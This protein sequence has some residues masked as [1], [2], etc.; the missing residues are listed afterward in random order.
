MPVNERVTPR[1]YYMMMNQTGSDKFDRKRDQLH[2]SEWN[3]QSL[4]GKKRY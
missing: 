1:G 4:V 3:G 2:S